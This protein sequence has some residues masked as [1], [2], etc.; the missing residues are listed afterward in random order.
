MNHKRVLRV[1]REESSL[2]Q[3]QKRFVV[4]TDSQHGHHTYPNRLA[5]LVLAAPDQEWVADITHIRLPT[6]FVHP[7]AI[8][9][10]FSLRC[11]GWALSRKIDTRLKLAALEMALTI[12][13]SAAG[14]IHQ[15]K[16]GIQYAGSD[17]VERLVAEGAQVT[18][19]ATGSPY[20]NA[21]AE[22]VFKTLKYEEVYLKHDAT[23]AEVEANLV[24]F[25]ESVYNIKRLHSSLGY[26]PTPEFEAAYA[27][28]TE[29]LTLTT[30]R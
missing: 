3:L 8:F 13:T 7:A 19:A 21:K 17:D 30:V 6:A 12:R 22:S 27:Q 20:E 16:C 9:D 24:P 14:L 4:T 28:A 26:V 15:S 29:K 5:D 1:M 10:A 18:M 23:F 11:V 2:C 25:I